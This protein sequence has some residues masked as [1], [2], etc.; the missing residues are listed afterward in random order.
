MAKVDQLDQVHN[1]LTKYWSKV[2][3]VEANSPDAI[4]LKSETITA[5]RCF[6]IKKAAKVGKHLQM[7]AT[8]T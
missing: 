8:S 2:E 5:R 7:L 3:E 4:A 1:G 6:R